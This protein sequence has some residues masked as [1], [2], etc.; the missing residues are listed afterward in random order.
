MQKVFIAVVILSVFSLLAFAYESSSGSYTTNY[1]IGSG[2]FQGA[3]GTYDVQ[4]VITTPPVGVFPGGIY[5]ADVGPCYGEIC[6]SAATASPAGWI[7]TGI[8]G[9]NTAMAGFPVQ[10]T[11]TC[12]FDGVPTVCPKAPTTILWSSNAT[13]VSFDLN[14]TNPTYFTG[15][16]LGSKEVYANFS[17][18]SSETLDFKCPTK[19]IQIVSTPTCSISLNQT[20]GIVPPPVSTLVT[21]YFSPGPVLNF[22]GYCDTGVP[23]NFNSPD[24]ATFT[25]T[26][27][28]SIAGTKK[29]T[30]NGSVFNQSI[31]CTP[32]I[33]TVVNGPGPTSTPIPSPGAGSILRIEGGKVVSGTTNAD[34]NEKGIV[35]ILLNDPGTG[36]AST[37]PNPGITL[38]LTE[39]N[40]SGYVKD[41]QHG[42]IDYQRP[43]VYESK[44]QLDS[45]E[46]VFDR[47]NLKADASVDLY[48]DTYSDSESPA[49]I[50][51]TEKKALPETDLIAIVALVLASLLFMR[52]QAR[53]GKK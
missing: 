36:L 32:T 47:K 39:V 24:D 14:N 19:K 44:I 18:P 50:L 46:P 51:V 12:T 15:T 38:V 13:D 2:G 33:F 17:N 43:G 16:I 7:C 22:T 28:Y 11:A 4:Y 29:I 6:P 42:S 53:S 25:G 21:V 26:C 5:E 52:V 23:G 9:P 31:V 3:A 48:G 41:I 1:N 49:L 8:T 34:F 20:S 27:T 37:D 40:E 30:A 35:T 10:L 45:N